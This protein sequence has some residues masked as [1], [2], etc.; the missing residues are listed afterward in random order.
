MIK[1]LAAI[2]VATV[3]ALGTTQVFAGKAVP[4][5]DIDGGWSVVCHQ[6]TSPGNSQGNVKIL[7]VPSQAADSEVNDHRGTTKPG[8]PGSGHDDIVAAV[9]WT[10]SDAVPTL[11]DCDGD[12]F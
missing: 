7:F 2:G 5:H 9:G 4:K 10:T 11:S 3:L 1:Q 8:N 6:R 12:S